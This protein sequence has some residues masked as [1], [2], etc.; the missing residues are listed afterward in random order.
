MDTRRFTKVQSVLDSLKIRYGQGSENCRFI[1]SNNLETMPNINASTTTVNTISQLNDMNPYLSLIINV[2][3]FNTIDQ[4]IT[5]NS[6]LMNMFNNFVMSYNANH[7]FYFNKSRMNDLKIIF[8][9]TRMNE[10]TNTA[11]YNQKNLNNNLS[12]LNIKYAYLK[13]S[14]EGVLFVDAPGNNI[15]NI[16]HSFN[17]DNIRDCQI[18]MTPKNNVLPKDMLISETSKC[19]LKMRIDIKEVYDNVLN[20]CS[21]KSSLYQCN[22]EA[23]YIQ[24]TLSNKCSRKLVYNIQYA[25]DNNYNIREFIMSKK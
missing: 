24:E 15:K 8:R 2:F 4:A 22:L 18:L 5:F 7:L 16:L 21:Y 10:I 20:I 14:N 3:C 23:K 17:Y 12:N 19:C 1:F 11:G 9:T 13:F 25:F 6:Q